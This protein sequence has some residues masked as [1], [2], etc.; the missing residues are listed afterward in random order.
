MRV[1]ARPRNVEYEEGTGPGTGRTARRIDPSVGS[2]AGNRSANLGGGL[3]AF[4]LAQRDK[5]R[6]MGDINREATI[7]REQ[8]L[9]YNP[10]SDTYQRDSMYNRSGL[11]YGRGEMPQAQA[12]PQQPQQPAMTS[13]Q[14][15]WARMAAERQGAGARTMGG[16]DQSAQGIGVSAF[17]PSAASMVRPSYYIPNPYLGTREQN[18]A[19]AKAAG[20]FDKVR[21]DY[22]KKNEATG[23][24]MDEEGNITRSPEAYS[25]IKQEERDLMRGMWR[26]PQTLSK[27]EE[28]AGV[29]S[30]TAI[31]SR[32]GKGSVT[33]SAPGAARPPSM[34]KDEFGKFVP[35]NQYLERKKYVQGTKGM[36][37]GN[38]F[39]RKIQ[40]PAQKSNPYE[41]LKEKAKKNTLSFNEESKF[42][43]FKRHED[44]IPG[45]Y[46]LSEK[47][48]QKMLLSLGNKK[49]KE[50]AASK[51]GQTP[52]G[53][54]DEKISTLE[55]YLEFLNKK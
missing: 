41:A 19:N 23:L 20:Q 7:G 55:E 45:I 26:E 13:Q 35:M 31:P 30:K 15:E 42:N 39:V 24:V 54:T 4:Y 21:A 36:N 50:N 34:V 48:A 22:N 47:E 53:D 12:Q 27:E 17:G 49:N 51:T 37:G 32:Y 29:V 1:D 5:T 6:S 33:I 18:I 52:R 2:S 8:G 16:M 44:V 25:K 43:M 28:A 46:N 11:G 38:S 10:Y 14:Q 40:E 3:D 9:M